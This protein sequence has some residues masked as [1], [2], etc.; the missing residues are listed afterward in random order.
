MLA[1]LAAPALVAVLLSG[2]STPTLS[3]KDR[4][5]K[6]IRNYGVVPVYPMREDVFIGQLRM[7]RVNGDAYSLDSRKFGS[8]DVYPEY[9][10]TPQPQYPKTSTLPAK[11]S[12]WSQPV[13]SLRP[14]GTEPDRLRLAALPRLELVRITGAELAG[15]G[16]GGSGN[17]VAGARADSQQTVTVSLKGIETI[18]VSDDKVAPRFHNYLATRFS[19]DGEPRDPAFIQAV[20]QAAGALGAK[21]FG[22]IRLALVTRVMYA[23]SIDFAYGDTFAA[24][25]RAAVGAEI[26]AD[27]LTKP[28]DLQADKPKAAEFD[29]AKLIAVAPGVSGRLTYSS[30]DGL[31]LTEDYER[32]LAF[33]VDMM[34]VKLTGFSPALCAGAF[35]GFAPDV[36]DPGDSTTLRD[37]S[38]D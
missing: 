29:M 27:D 17:F 10:D 15:G 6:S 9:V 14:V 30:K 7:Y 1:R 36:R 11:G 21:S 26:S 23:R 31:S 20:C 3:V 33:G 28:A 22:D 32:P 2:C 12:A 4:W 38:E 13:G 24:A 34:S 37:R 5:A 16:G 25:L 18:E 8:L 35:K 19:A